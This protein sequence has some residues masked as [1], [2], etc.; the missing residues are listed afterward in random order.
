MHTFLVDLSCS[1]TV[2]DPRQ[3]VLITPTRDNQSFQTKLLN[4]KEIKDKTKHML[5][6]IRST[7][8]PASSSTGNLNRLAKNLAQKNLTA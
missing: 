8:K 3:S 5:P 2:L 6:Q 7:Q 4:Q 1:V